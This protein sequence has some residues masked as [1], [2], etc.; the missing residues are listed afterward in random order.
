MDEAKRDALMSEE[1]VK[2]TNLL[3]DNGYNV[4]CVKSGETTV[5]SENVGCFF[6]VNVSKYKPIQK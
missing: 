3:K 2:L 5:Y 1:L 4:H 6:T